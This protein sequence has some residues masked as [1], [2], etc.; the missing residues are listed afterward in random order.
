VEKD[1]P[2]VARPWAAPRTGN[3]A[4]GI[5]SSVRDQL[6]YARFHLGDGSTADGTRLLSQQSMDF[7]QTPLAPPG[8]MFDAVG[9]SWMLRDIAGLRVVS[10]GG[11]ANG[12]VSAFTLAP[13]RQFAYTMLT[14]ADRGGALIGEV[15]RW[16]YQHYLRL[17]R[18]ADPVLLERSEAEL[19]QYV[20]R[21]SSPNRVL[22]VSIV[23]GALT[24][25]VTGRFLLAD[26]D[27]QPPPPPPVRLG[28]LDT[29]R[30]MFLN[31]PF[32]GD[33]GE[34]LRRADGEVFGIR[35]SGRIR[36]REA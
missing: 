25:Q 3:P 34:F 27:S 5:C 16:I 30:F 10:H 22:E 28:F 7:M 32:R 26:D 35:A 19:R 36:L 6:R 29:D 13:K 21:Y 14:N 12:Q 9:V 18:P 23:D 31:E 1:R 15:S 11:G 20:G 24:L 8:G 17:E 33:R 2:R 4:G